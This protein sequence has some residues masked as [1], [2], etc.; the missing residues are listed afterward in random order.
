[1]PDDVTSPLNVDELG[2]LLGNIFHESLNEKN[3]RAS[4]AA[5]LK[6]LE[7]FFPGI[8]TNIAHDETKKLTGTCTVS[9]HVLLI[10]IIARALSSFSSSQ[11]FSYKIL[12]LI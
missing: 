9:W 3:G 7:A 2:E 1:M 5:T 4:Y 6:S 11:V 8:K 10:M 12:F